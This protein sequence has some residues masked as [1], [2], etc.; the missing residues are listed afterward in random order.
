MAEYRI[1]LQV[2]DGRC[3]TQG[4]HGAVVLLRNLR[5]PTSLTVPT[6]LSEAARILMILFPAWPTERKFD[7]ERPERGLHAPRAVGEGA[8][9]F[10]TNR[11][12]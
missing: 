7:A 1:G 12:V 2:D 11:A 8:W 9:G 10:G 4:R 3:P 6:A 5:G